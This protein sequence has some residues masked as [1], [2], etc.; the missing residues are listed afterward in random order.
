[1]LHL[2][3]LSASLL[4]SLPLVLVETSRL[5]NLLGKSHSALR[6]CCRNNV[7]FYV[8][9][10]PP[11]VYVGILNS[12]PGPIIHYFNIRKLWVS[13][14]YAEVGGSSVKLAENLLQQKTVKLAAN[15]LQQ[16]T[17]KLAGNLLQQKTVKLAENLL[18]QKRSNFLLT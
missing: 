7:M 5:A 4:C 16:K 13:L 12:I 18:Q 10:F 14:R 2:F 8:S 9:S 3:I 6:V 1:M 11:G 17:A 15:L